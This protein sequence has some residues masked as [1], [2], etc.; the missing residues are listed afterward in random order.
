MA[1]WWLVCATLAVL[2]IP[3]AAAHA[4]LGSSDPAAGAAVSVAPAHVLLD[5]TETVDAAGTHA[6]VAAA[7]GTRVDTAQH[8]AGPTRLDVQLGTIS[9][10]EYRVTWTSLSTDGDTVE[11]AF[12]FS[13]GNG[14]AA[15]T[16]QTGHAHGGW[17]AQASLLLGM[18]VPL[19]MLGFAWQVV[20][21]ADAK[22]RRAVTEAAAVVCIAGVVGAVYGIGDAVSATPLDAWSW[23]TRTQAG[24]LF[25]LRAVALVAAGVLLWTASGS[26]LNR[27]RAVAGGAALVLAVACTAWTSHAAAQP[28]LRLLGVASDIAHMGAV[29]AWLGGIVALLVWLPAASLDDAR[30]AVAAA[31]PTAL[32]LAALVAAS[33]TLNAVLLVGSRAALLHSSYG[34]LVLAKAGLLAVTLALG[35]RQRAAAQRAAA[36]GS[37]RPLSRALVA[38]SLAMLALLVAT[39][40]L[41]TLA[42]PGG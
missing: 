8:L 29:A 7:N 26:S 24:P 22:A 32:L 37:V 1:R 6:Q 19:G 9:R 18:L 23:L 34:W 17:F 16:T 21:P 15:P 40:V 20:P 31:T 25:A 36:A 2:A 35:L 33:G 14:T 38:E 10:G 13:V 11:G 5:F 30:T 4:R 3:G 42:P 41:T 27:R 28:H 39:G 12:S